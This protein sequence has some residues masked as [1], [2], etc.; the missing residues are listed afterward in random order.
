MG[1]P[2]LALIAF[3]LMV[4]L[5]LITK[6]AVV[7]AIEAIILVGGFLLLSPFLFAYA[8]SRFILNN[9][10]SFDEWSKDR[11]FW[12]GKKRSEKLKRKISIA[13]SQGPLVLTI[14]GG[15]KEYREETLE[16]KKHCLRARRQAPGA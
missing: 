5:A 7:I 4:G 10:D 8:N 1:L 15:I 11:P 12:T 13:T 14:Y 6:S 3:A 2:V 16:F 9:K